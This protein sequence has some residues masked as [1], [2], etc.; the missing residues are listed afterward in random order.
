MTAQ[1]EEISDSRSGDATE[2]EP[3]TEDVAVRLQN[4]RKTFNDGQIV[5]CED[6]NLD[7][8][9]DELVVFLGPSGCGKTTTLRMISGLEQPDSGSISIEGQN[10]IGKAPKDRNLA[11]VFQNIALYPT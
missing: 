10:V 6:F 4:I 1:N 11:F 2:V 7:V 8:A 3:S 5:A 9:E